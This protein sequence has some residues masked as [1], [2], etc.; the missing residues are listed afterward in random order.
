MSE[1]YVVA[2]RRGFDPGL[3]G[4]LCTAT[5]QH[6]LVHDVGA[7]L[8]QSPTSAMLQKGS[9]THYCA[10]AVSVRA[11]P[12]ANPAEVCPR[13]YEMLRSCAGLE[14]KERFWSQEDVARQFRADEDFKRLRV[15]LG[16]AIPGGSA[17][18]VREEDPLDFPDEPVIPAKRA[19]RTGAFDRLLYWL[20]AVGRGRT[21][22]FAEV[23]RTLG[24]ASSPEEVR[25]V[26]RRFVLL[27]HLWLSESGTEWAIRRAAAIPLASDPEQLCL[28][29]QRLP[30]LVL[31]LQRDAGAEL[32]PQAGFD[33][34]SKIVV[35]R[36]DT[37]LAAL[38]AGSEG[39][40][41]RVLASSLSVD[42]TPDA[43][44]WRH[45]QRT[46]DPPL[47][48]GGVPEV[49]D[50]HR[51]VR[52]G[53]PAFSP[54]GEVILATGLYRVG[55]SLERTGVPCLYDSH[56]KR[57]MTGDW[58]GLRFMSR[59]LTEAAAPIASFDAGCG[60]LTIQRGWEW[61]LTHERALVLTTGRLP[62]V[63][64]D[65]RQFDGVT[66]AVAAVLCDRLGV[67]LNPVAGGEAC[68][69]S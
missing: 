44:A 35:E 41:P 27:G 47:P 63:T 31:R 51:Y 46:V 55:G 64:S 20:S 24:V 19:D 2:C 32:A 65:L 43:V 30:G 21:G 42:E 23:C 16:D 12:Q 6:D 57:W 3:S 33:G 22:A 54:T 48:S 66:P 56:E 11:A 14:V 8:V 1:L 38:N 69:M 52:V 36:S 29:G 34:P 39:I 18:L 13:V 7:V 25:S 49:H 5:R 10:V 58:Y 45:A 37:V 50:G 53:S 59:R 40:R 61:P 4:T 62:L 9:L 15:S 68:T 28:C 17:E 60:T 67:K 26:R